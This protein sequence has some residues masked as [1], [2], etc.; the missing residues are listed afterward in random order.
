[1]ARVLYG[2][3]VT[4][5]KGSI[6]GITFHRNTSGEI[7]KLR[8]L[9]K[10]VKSYSQMLSQIL[11]SDAINSWSLLSKANQALWNTFASLHSRYNYFNEE[12]T[13]T[14]MNWYTSIYINSV[15]CGL[16]PPVSPP[17]Y[18]LPNTP[19]AFHLTSSPSGIFIVFNEAYNHSAVYLY[20][21]MTFPNY[22]QSLS[23]RT[24]IRLCSIA[25]PSSD[26]V[27]D[28][29]D[30]YLSLFE[31]DSLPSSPDGSANILCS[32]AAIKQSS[33]I[34]SVFTSYLHR[35][36]ALNT[37]NPLT[38]FNSQYFRCALLSD[39]RIVCAGSFTT[40]QGVAR[41]YVAL[42]LPDG[43]LDTSFDSSTGFNAGV[44]HIIVT[45]DDRI[46]LMGDFTTYKGVT[47]NRVC[48][49]DVY[50][51]L[52]ESFDC[53]VAADNSVTYG[54]ISAD[55]ILFLVGSFTHYNGVAAGRIAAVYLDG[56]TYEYS[57]FGDGFNSTVQS[58]V[59]VGSNKL[60]CCG[61]F[62]EY[63]GSA[64]VRICVLEMNG[65]V[66][67]AF[68]PAAGFNATVYSVLVDSSNNIYCFG[69]FTTYKG[70]SYNRALM[71]DSS[72][73]VVAAF[74]VGTGFDGIVYKALFDAN[75]FIVVSGYFTTYKGA[76]CK[77]IVRLRLDGSVDSSFFVSQITASFIISFIFDSS[78]RIIVVGDF[79]SLNSNSVKYIARLF[80][81]GSLNI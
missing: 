62:S 75:G 17:E 53:S 44:R 71:L 27:Y 72:A 42:L 73:N 4:S 24:L 43:T 35:L 41:L 22:A 80:A 81:D 79:T 20:I 70:V 31:L 9:S 69:N 1:M 40:Y 52:D 15:L 28:L 5:L 30:D 60:V 48:I 46:I 55:N 64:R 19:V 33:L 77:Y 8:P 45:S 25:D 58:V 10:S 57:D 6:G 74:V 7:A 51:S 23:N 39:G 32:I 49:L 36:P 61:D 14:G 3:E 11:F 68:N 66:D 29:T 26:V 18:S 65:G 50:G 37:F 38:S 47:T 16:T 67:A 34:A 13:L 78:D 56:S 2:P 21:F 63:D 12:K 54:V 59:V 76:T